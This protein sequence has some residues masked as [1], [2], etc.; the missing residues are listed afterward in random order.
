MHVRLTM[1]Q[2][3][4]FD[5]QLTPIKRPNPKLKLFSS[6]PGGWTL[7]GV[8]SFKTCS[9]PNKELLSFK[10]LFN[11]TSICYVNWHCCYNVKNIHNKAI[12]YSTADS[13]GTKQNSSLYWK[14]GFQLTLAGTIECHWLYT[15]TYLVE[16]EILDTE[17]VLLVDFM[18]LVY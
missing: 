8:I 2:Y 1:L 16:T 17:D 9:S 12:Y 4:C 15:E 18:Y 14:E 13:T 7:V 10:L 3:R 6:C 11:P 5:W